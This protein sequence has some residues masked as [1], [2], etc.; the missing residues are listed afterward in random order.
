[1][2]DAPSIPAVVKRYTD[3]RDLRGEYQIDFHKRRLRQLASFIRQGEDVLDVGCNSGYLVEYLPFGCSWTGLDPSET[4]VKIAQER[5]PNKDIRVGIAELLPYP[6]KSFDVVVIAQVLERVYD[7]TLV[8]EEA[9]RVARRAIVGDT[10]HES[11]PWGPSHL[12]KHPFDVR[13]FTH[14]T[15]R[16]FLLAY[17]SDVTIQTVTWGSG[18]VMYTFE[19]R[20]DG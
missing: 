16:T 2:A 10:P 18:P 5:Y 13:C 3:F 6:D 4:A 12:E 20:V 15:L 7:P 19:A 9:V 14:E 8:M 17:S 11:G 1:M